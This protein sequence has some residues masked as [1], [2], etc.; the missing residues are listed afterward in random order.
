MVSSAETGSVIEAQ[1]RMARLFYSQLESFEAGELR[2][3][4]DCV[5]L[6]KS[7]GESRRWLRL[8]KEVVAEKIGMG[9]GS[10][11]AAETPAFMSGILAY[12]SH[13]FREMASVDESGDR[14][15]AVIS[16]SMM[17]RFWVI[18]V[19]AAA[20]RGS[21][22]P[23]KFPEAGSKAAAVAFREMRRAGLEED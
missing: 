23:E 12:A 14:L 11:F 8:S 18:P 16:H 17:P 4:T 19:D 6:A 22:R 20:P 3:I 10:V 7:L 15:R 2:E 5:K 13:A 9:K 21:R 1:N